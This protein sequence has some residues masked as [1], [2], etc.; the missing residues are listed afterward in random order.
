VGSIVSVPVRDAFHGR[1][2][3]S[4]GV[5]RVSTIQVIGLAHVNLSAAAGVYA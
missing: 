5:A 4:P 1:R 2:S 3:A